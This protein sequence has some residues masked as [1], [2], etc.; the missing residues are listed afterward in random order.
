MTATRKCKQHSPCYYWK[1]EKTEVDVN[2]DDEPVH[3]DE[4][5]DAE[6]DDFDADL[7]VGSVDV[8]AS[9]YEHEW[10]RYHEGHF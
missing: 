10:I 9:M 6:F 3:Q 8:W 1:N 4:L 7:D 5:A 2:P